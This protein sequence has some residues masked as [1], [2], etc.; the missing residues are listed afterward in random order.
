[1]PDLTFTDYHHARRT[2][3][4]M[5]LSNSEGL[6]VPQ[7]IPTAPLSS[8]SIESHSTAT[9]IGVATG[10]ARHVF[11]TGAGSSD[12][13]KFS[14][15]V[16]QVGER[17]AVAISD[18]AALYHSWHPN[19]LSP[20][21]EMVLYHE[22]ANGTP[23]AFSWAK[24]FRRSEPILKPSTVERFNDLATKWRNTRNSVGSVLEMCSNFAYQQII[25]MGQDAIPLILRDL[26]ND[27]DHWFWA[28]GAITGANPVVE[29]HRGRLKLM[30]QDWFAWAKKQGY[31]W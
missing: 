15:L 7:F 9:G 28:L 25:G 12:F 16:S 11:I 22:G 26:E 23:V 27:I 20:L 2:L 8:D 13:R 24:Y 18:R 14:F 6:V 10:A 30:A 3:G 17:V 1:M 31:R 19:T 29:Q 5:T 21:Q 4:R